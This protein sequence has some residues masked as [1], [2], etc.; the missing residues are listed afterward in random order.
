MNDSK[1]QTS[2]KICEL[3]F[4]ISDFLLDTS[5]NRVRLKSVAVPTIFE[6]GLVE[7][8]RFCIMA[9]YVV[10]EL[11]NG[12]KIHTNKLCAFSI[13]NLLSIEWAKTKCELLV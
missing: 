9:E 4:K 11:V 3:H 12:R 7:L 1:G 10:E 2:R 5:E 8:Y 13:S 6:N